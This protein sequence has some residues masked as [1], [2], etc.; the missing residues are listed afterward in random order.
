MFDAI[1][2]LD[3][4]NIQYDLEGKN[5]TEGWANI[6]CPFCQD[7][8]N[9]GGFNLAVGYYNCWNCGHHFL[10]QLV[11]E[12]LTVLPYK[13]KQIVKQYSID[14]QRELKK[15]TTKRPEK[16]QLPTG[17]GKMKRKHREYLEGRNFDPD[18]L[19]KEFDLQGT[20]HLGPYKFRIIAPIYYKNKLVSYQGRDITGKAENRYKACAN[21]KEV[22]HHKDI[23]YNLDNAK[24]D[25]VIIVEGL[26]DVWRIGS[27]GVATFGVNFNQKQIQILIKRYKQFFICFDNEPKANEQARKLAVMLSSL[28]KEVE[29]VDFG[30]NDFADLAQEDADYLK[31]ILFNKK[32]Q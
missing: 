26:F 22:I 10:D 9:H 13:A 2:F 24:G 23:L 28:G 14:Q 19:E 5:V 12:L 11:A 27:G 3:D 15:R 17:T 16:I 4:N 25:S 18:K 32:N 29:T 7:N 31:K 1:Q 20:G 6:A 8:S 30:E 21:E